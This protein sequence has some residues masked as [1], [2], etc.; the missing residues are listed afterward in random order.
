MKNEIIK[1][2]EKILNKRLKNYHVLTNDG[3]NLNIT[4]GI[5]NYS[6]VLDSDKNI[7]SIYLLGS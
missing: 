6:V 2:V 7:K 1:K 4:N 5:K 3:I